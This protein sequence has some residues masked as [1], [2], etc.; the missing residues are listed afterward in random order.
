MSG[1]SIKLTGGKELLEKLKTL[2]DKVQTKV[3]RH[4]VADGINVIRNDIRSRAP[5]LTENEG[6]NGPHLPGTLL[7][8]IRARVLRNP[9]RNTV[10][11]GILILPEAFYWRFNELGTR[12]QPARPFIRPAVDGLGHVACQSVIEYAKDG[13]EKE[14]KG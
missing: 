11:A 1:F 8:S 13:V 2:P 4:A 5:I 7:K 14:A 9:D 12:H 6:L 10:K 3:M